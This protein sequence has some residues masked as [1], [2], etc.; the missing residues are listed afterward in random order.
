MHPR[1]LH[2]WTLDPAEAIRIQTALRERLVLEWDRRT[3]STIGG[4]DI[5]L[6]EDT[7]RAA[8]VVLS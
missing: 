5:G 1:D 2:P 7:A 3:V 6:Q 8:N 4:V